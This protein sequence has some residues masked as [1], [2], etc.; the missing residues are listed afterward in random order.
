MRSIRCLLAT[1]VVA[2]TVLLTAAVPASAAG[3]STTRATAA[4]AT[5]A[6][7]SAGSF[8]TSL[9]AAVQQA[10]AK[11]RQEAANAGYSTSQCVP[12]GA[13]NIE[14]VSADWLAEVTIQCTR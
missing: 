5:Q 10:Y 8:A 11:A 1:T 14:G 12:L 9:D 13:P 4:P 6:V 3:I 7:F 2:G